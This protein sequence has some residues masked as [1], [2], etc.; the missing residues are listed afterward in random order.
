MQQHYATINAYADGAVDVWGFMDLDLFDRKL[1]TGS[2]SATPP[3]DSRLSIFDLGAAMVSKGTWLRSAY[4]IRDA[5]WSVVRDFDPMLRNVI[6]MEGTDT[7]LEGK[8][9]YAKLGLSDD[10]PYRME[11]R[12][13]VRKSH[14]SNATDKTAS[15]NN[16]SSILTEPLVLASTANW[17]PLTLFTGNSTEGTW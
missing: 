1:R 10:C 14:S 7:R 12:F 11:T 6:E 15:S 8:V 5:I 3:V 9:R 16:G 17:H 13:S 2:V 4:E